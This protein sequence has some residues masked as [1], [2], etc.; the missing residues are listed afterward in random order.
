MNT[1]F[2]LLAQH[3]G[4]II[5]PIEDVCWDYFSRLNQTKLVQ[6]ISADEIAIPLV[7]MEAARNAQKVSTFGI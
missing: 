3:G 5:I 7:R 6:R 1:Q 2:L 4:K